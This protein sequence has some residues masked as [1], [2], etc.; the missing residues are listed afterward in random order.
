MEKKKKQHFIPRMY[1]R[2]FC[3]NVNEERCYVYDSHTSDIKLSLIDKIGFENYLYEIR[4]K[5]E[6]L[7]PEGKHAVENAF[8]KIESDQKN[9]I[10][11]II[12]SVLAGNEWITLERDIR[13]SL[14][15]FVGLMILRN[16]IVRNQIPY[17]A[18]EVLAL[19]NLKECE[20]TALWLKTISVCL[21]RLANDLLK[22]E[23][24]F[25]QT[26]SEEPFITS[27]EPFYFTGDNLDEV[28]MPLSPKVAVKFIKNENVLRNIDV[29]QKK[30][31]SPEEVVDINT[32]MVSI[33]GMLFSNSKEALV[34]ALKRK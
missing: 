23:L 15:G 11:A 29:C 24:M 30:I 19:K 18:D 5:G 27:T 10:T 33:R 21:E 9:D 4:D 17:V 22:N 16:P 20:N 34:K 25:L 14:A 3:Y 13:E 31:L 28:Y 8:A 1:L 6:F 12:D 32:A 2:N 7:F 26:R